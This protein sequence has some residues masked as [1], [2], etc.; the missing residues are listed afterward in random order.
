[1]NMT[2]DLL[3]ATVDDM[4]SEDYKT[5]LIAEYKQV[6]IR[7]DA[8]DRILD[9]LDKGQLTFTLNCP[10]SVLYDQWSI[11][12]KYKTILEDRFIYEDVDVEG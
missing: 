3:K 7:L 6:S 11:M 9:D 10:V 5:R 4:L 2:H 1:M 12:K 8:L